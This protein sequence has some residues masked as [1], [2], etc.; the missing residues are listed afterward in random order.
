MLTMR[1]VSLAAALLAAA[2]VPIMAQGLQKAGGQQP[3][4]A[5]V[6]AEP[7]QVANSGLCQAVDPCLAA[8]ATPL[9]YQIWFGPTYASAA[10][11]DSAW[12]FAEGGSLG[13]RLGAGLQLYG[14]IGFNHAGGSTDILGTIG[15]QRLADPAGATL[16]DRMSLAVY[17]DQFVNTDAD[18]YL[19]GFRFEVGYALSPN[20]TVG[21]IGA[22][23]TSGGQDVTQITP[24]GAA[25]GTFP[26][27]SGA[28]GYAS[29]HIG[30]WSAMLT[31][32]YSNGNESAIYGGSVRR[33]L[34]PTTGVT[35]G[36]AAGEDVDFV[37]ALAFD[38]RFPPDYKPEGWNPR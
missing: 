38:Y 11:G 35:F 17:W 34:T 10:V 37:S 30:P 29:Y 12:G 7:V 1:C 24:I 14:G 5:Q 23:S 28:A 6:Q 36:A 31:I 32:G 8:C 9:M 2:G 21:A 13:Y 22:V 18:E 16:H 4:Q 27:E 15:I 20:Y 33:E 3:V 19:H 25:L 26:G